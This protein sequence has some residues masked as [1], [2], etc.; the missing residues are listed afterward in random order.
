[1]IDV[2]KIIKNAMD[3]GASDVHYISGLKPMLRINRDLISL[4]EYE[5]ITKD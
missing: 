1:M 3:R 4:D 5:V 2:N